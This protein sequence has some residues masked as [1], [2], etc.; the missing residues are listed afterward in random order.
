[1]AFRNPLPIIVRK[2]GGIETAQ[3]LG[4][5]HGLPLHANQAKD[6]MSLPMFR[7]QARQQMSRP[8]SGAI[9]SAA[10]PRHSGEKVRL[11][12]G[13]PVNCVADPLVI[14]RYAKDREND[15]GSNLNGCLDRFS[16]RIIC[17]C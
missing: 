12:Q 13:L 7:H 2:L 6:E 9:Y 15:V 10:D 11:S 3:K 5:R 4:Q 17:L 8:L 16:D 14:N 1:M